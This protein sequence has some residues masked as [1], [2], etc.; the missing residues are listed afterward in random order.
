[1]YDAIFGAQNFAEASLFDIP[2]LRAD[3][4]HARMLIYCRVIEE[5]QVLNSKG[6]ASTF[7]DVVDPNGS[8]YHS[9]LLGNE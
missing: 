8:S 7:I 2:V 6:G 1:M 4:L 9:Q 3:F 5:G